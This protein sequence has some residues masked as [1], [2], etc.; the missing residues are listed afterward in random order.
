MIQL[1]QIDMDQGAFRLRGL[2][3]DVPEGAYAV[4]MGSTGSGKTTLLEVIC[5]LREPARGR[6]RVAGRDVTHATPAAREVGYVPQDGA[7]FKTMTVYENLA[8]ALLIRRETRAAIDARVKAVAGLLGIQSLLDRLPAGLSGGE[9]Q[10]VALGRALS[11]QPRVLLLDEPL[12]ALD[13]ATRRRIMALLKDVHARTGV[14]V[15][16]VTHNVEEAESLGTTRLCI[17]DGG[18][19]RFSGIERKESYA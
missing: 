17:R 13:D 16:H 4:L 12:A 8:F 9:R 6:V 19:E 5:G 18:V 7:L 3:L 11:F 14:T 1:Q 10:R 2:S 15:L